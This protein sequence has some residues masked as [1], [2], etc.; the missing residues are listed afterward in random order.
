MLVPVLV[1]ARQD[2]HGSQATAVMGFDQER[3]AHHFFCSTM[4]AQSM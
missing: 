4:A 3:T 1:A 2:H